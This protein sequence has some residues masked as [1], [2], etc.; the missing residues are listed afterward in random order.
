MDADKPGEIAFVSNSPLGMLSINTTLQCIKP[1]Y[2]TIIFDT[3][4]E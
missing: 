3:T 1:T 2:K 4:C